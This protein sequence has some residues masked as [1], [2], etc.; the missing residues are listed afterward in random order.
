MPGT[1]WWVSA[2]QFQGMPGGTTV[3]GGGDS[4]VI[5]PRD[6]MDGKRM[7]QGFAPGASYPDGYL[8]TITNRQQDKLL[9]AVQSRLT[10]RA[11]Q[12]GV[13]KGEKVGADSYSWT[14]ECNPDAGLARQAQ[15]QLADQEGGIV[16][17][18]PRYSPSGNPVEK[19]TAMGKTATLPVGQQDQVAK[20]FGVD[21]A[22]S[23]LPLTQTDPD[24]AASMAH[25]LPSY[26]R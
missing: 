19:L 3:G 14:A 12:R 11:Y 26:S 24:K 17:R 22:K 13:H 8:G 1:D 23:S 18:V 7:A 6:P 25:L 10:D 2:G 16:F 21:P 20:Q 15:A 4:S 9:G 5:T